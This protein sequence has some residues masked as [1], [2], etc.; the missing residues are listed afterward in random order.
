MDVQRLRLSLYS[1]NLMSAFNTRGGT[2]HSH[3]RPQGV[4]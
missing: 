2:R 3:C 1:L 4:H